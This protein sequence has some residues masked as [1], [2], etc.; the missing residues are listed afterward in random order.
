M[1]MRWIALGAALALG[2]A[3][4]PRAQEAEAEVRA[5][6]EAWADAFNRGAPDAVCEIY[7]KDLVSVWRGSPDGGRAEACARIAEALSDK[8]ADLTYS[9]EIEEIIVAESGDLAV[10]RVTWT[11][12][13]ERAGAVATSQERGMDVFRREADGAWRMLRSLAFSTEPDE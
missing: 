9:P 6:I 4:A 7:S 12:G 10:A 2:L 11:L 3:G 5:R 8:T 13:V 1:N